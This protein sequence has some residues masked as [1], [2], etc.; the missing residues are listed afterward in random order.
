MFSCIY[1]LKKYIIM[2]LLILF[3]IKILEG[4]KIPK[5]QINIFIT[6]F[7]SSSV[8]SLIYFQSLP[9]VDYC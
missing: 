9:N 2:Q 8:L 7:S 1:H 5:S 6:S 4:S 3:K